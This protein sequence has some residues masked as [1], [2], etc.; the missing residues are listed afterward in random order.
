MS[1]GVE[2]LRRDWRRLGDRDPLWAVLMRPGT[3][4][5]GWDD[6]AFLATGAAEVDAAMR[7]LAGLG[8][9]VAGGRALDFGCGAGRTAQA[10]AGHVDEVVGVDISPGM[11]EIARRLERTGRVSFILHEGADLRDLADAS[12]DV[13]YSSLVIQHLPPA[14]AR[15]M[16]AELA[17]VTRPGGVVVVQVGG[18]PL[19][20]LKGVL[21]RYAPWPLIRWG[22]RVLLRYPA[23]MRMHGTTREELTAAL[24]L[25]DVEVLDVVPDDTYGGHW[26]YDR[27]YAHR[28][29]PREG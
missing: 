9:P 17:R 3:K 11:L 5:G 28:P 7:H 19:R 15:A 29:G 12:F 23:P 26:T 20:N 2:Q 10:L 1:D 13:V 6:A 25:H 8:H 24:A 22:Q 16:L 4:N 18:R 14:L 21:F 27:Y